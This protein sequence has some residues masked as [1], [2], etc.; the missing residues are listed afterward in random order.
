MARK[1]LIVEDELDTGRLLAEHLRRWGFEPTIMVE[2]RPAVSWVREQKPDLVL[3]DLL[4]PDIDGFEICELLKLERETNLIPIVMIT[5]LTSSDDKVRGLK[6]GANQ[7]LTKPFTA[8]ALHRAIQ[9]AF[10]WREEIKSQGTHGAVRFQLQSDMRYLDELNSLLSSMFLYSGLTQ[11]QAKQLTT[12][13]RELGTNAIEWGHR[14]QINEIVTVDYHIDAE[15]ITIVIRDTGPGFNPQHVPHAA[16]LDDPVSHMMVR[17]LLGLRDGGFGILM[18]R[19]LVD[20]LE[21]NETGNE[22]RLIKYFPKR[23]DR[24]ESQAESTAGSA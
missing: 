19:G 5:A 3:L 15:K 4:L 20:D 11:S 9:N 1:V 24:Q 23:T 17:E 12:A 21:Y 7:Y 13:V 18:S 10:L 22:V 6:V 14:K 8:D 16:S 2:G